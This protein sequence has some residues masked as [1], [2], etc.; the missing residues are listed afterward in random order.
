V[1]ATATVESGHSLG[2]IV[3]AAVR[4]GLRIDALHEH[5]ETVREGRGGV[6]PADAD[7]RYRLRVSGE[8]LPVLFTLLASR[9]A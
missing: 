5:F 4:A 6:L 7:A 3:T 8:L 9:P 1:S 2:E